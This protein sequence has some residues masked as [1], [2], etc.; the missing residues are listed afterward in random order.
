MGTEKARWLHISDLHILLN[1]PSWKVFQGNLFRFFEEH[2]EQK[3]DFVVVTGD[4]R[5]IMNFEDFGPAEGFIRELLE[6]LGLDREK[7]LYLVPGN[8]DIDILES[9]PGKPNGVKIRDWPAAELKKLLPDGLSPGAV[10]SNEE[11]DEWRETCE[12]EPADYLDRLCNVPRGGGTGKSDENWVHTSA[13]LEG[14]QAYEAMAK[15][16]IPWYS[17]VGWGP[18]TPHSREWQGADGLGFNLVHFNTALAADGSRGHYQALDLNDS[19]EVL[20]K[21]QNGK[22]T[23]ILAHNSF[24]DLHPRIQE[25]LKPSMSEARVCAWLCG[26]EHVFREDGRI[27]CRAAGGDYSVPIYV[28]GKGAPDHGDRD[29]EN[30]FYLFEL[31]GQ[32]LTVRRF[33]WGAEEGIRE[34]EKQVGRLAAPEEPDPVPEEKKRLLIGYLSCNPDVKFKEKYHLGHAYFIRCM[35][36]LRKSDHIML[37]TSSYVFKSNRTF[38]SVKQEA[39]YAKALVQR[40]QSCFGRGV[41]VIDIKQYL[42]EDRDPDDKEEK[43]LGYVANMELQLDRRKNWMGFIEDW[44]EDGEIETAAYNALMEVL[45]IEDPGSSYEKNEV[46]SFAY[47]LYKRPTWYS[48]SWM[49]N[50]MYFWN[51]QLYSLVT[52]TFGFDIAPDNIFIVEAKRNRYVWDAVSYCAKR[53]S[54]MNFPRVEYIENLLDKDCNLPMKSS[55]RE[56]AVYLAD[57]QTKKEYGPK[58]E[59]HVREMFGTGKS[60]DEICEEFSKRLG[61]DK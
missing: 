48:T 16:L 57:Y 19:V 44:K 43:L 41:P 1:S 15:R 21:I 59:K 34:A 5:N 33:S 61:L 32:A 36:N 29:S 40:W 53:F 11:A 23:L 20:Q 12:K 26:D 3:P 51:S 4:Y 55:N 35:D 47:L 6:R 22:P 13:L 37:L 9:D 10:L 27:A 49:A 14:F 28:C 8:H 30:G 45:K 39:N 18:A 17:A 60:P 42:Q 54:Y 25:Y 24:Y 58:F 31:E 50:F 38:E 7:D 56:K 52:G 46:M 2:P